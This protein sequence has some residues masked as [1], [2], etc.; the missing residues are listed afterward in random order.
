MCIVYI[1]YVCKKQE[2]FTDGPL[3][4]GGYELDL[5]ELRM[6]CAI[7]GKESGKAEACGIGAHPSCLCYPAKP[8]VF[9]SFG[10]KERALPACP[11]GEGV[12]GR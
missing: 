5:V 12:L 7:P 9:K 3:D 1:H 8:W 11:P 2:A 10:K 6:S 4:K